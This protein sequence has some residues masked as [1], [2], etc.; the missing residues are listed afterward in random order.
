MSIRTPFVS[1]ARLFTL[2]IDDETGRG[3]LAIPVS[4]GAIDTHERYALTPEQLERFLADEDAA[5]DFADEC[6]AREHDSLLLGEQGWRRGTPIAPPPAGTPLPPRPA[7][8]PAAPRTDAADAI[9]ASEPPAGTWFGPEPGVDLPIVAT[10]HLR[11]LAPLD[12]R[13]AAVAAAA[14]AGDLSGRE[15]L[16]DLLHDASDDILLETRLQAQRL[17]VVLARD[18]DFADPTTFRYLDD[19]PEEL[20]HDVAGL[21]RRMQARSAID[22]LVRVGRGHWRDQDV[23]RSIIPSLLMLVD[24]SDDERREEPTLVSLAKSAH[25]TLQDES[26]T[27]LLSGQP[28]SP[29]PAIERMRA[30]AIKAHASGSRSATWFLAP[31]LSLWSGI[32]GPYLKDVV[33]TDDDLAAVVGWADALDALPWVAGRKYVHGHDVDGGPSL[34]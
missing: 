13:V 17:L 20:L 32:P 25:R 6:R 27:Y 30:G 23:R 16:V 5:G 11:E 7:R 33:L 3:F 29:R 2:G 18:E 21:G 12:A 26:A 15:A 14:R 8:A 4:I 28:W 19:A 9:R 31:D 10:P 34:R 22:V 1:R 24:R